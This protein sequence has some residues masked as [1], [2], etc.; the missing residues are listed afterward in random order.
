MASGTAAPGTTPPAESSPTLKAG[1]SG[2]L[3]LFF[4]VGDMIGAG[5]FALV[6]EVGG[7]VGGAIWSAFAAALILAILTAGAYAELVTK[8]PRAG[9]AATYV[10]R[11]YRRHFVTFIIAFLVMASGV[12]SAATLS[13]AFAGD[14]FNQF[15]DVPLVPVALGFI[16]LVGLINFRGI[17]E[18][19]K[20]NLVLTLGSLLGLALIVVIGVAAVADGSA[21]VGRN[22]EFTEG[23]SVFAAV[24]AGAALAFYAL[25]GF[26]DSVNVAEETP[27]PTRSFPRTLFGG[28]L[29]AGIVYMLVT[30]AASSVVPT[31]DLA[32]SDGPLLEVVRQGP[33][34]L[35]LKLFAVVALMAV[36]NGALLNMIMASRLTYGM[37]TQGVVPRAFGR[38][39]AGRRTP[40]VA[41][42]FTTALAIVL[43]LTGD[44][45]LL[46]DVT[47]TL[48][49]FVFIVV[50]ATVIVLRRDRVEHDHFRTPI[51]LP[52][53]GIVTCVALLTQRDA[54]VWLRAG[55]I[56]ALGVVL[57]AVTR[58]ATGPPEDL[59]TERMR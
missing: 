34:D 43:I 39:H 27:N 52:V 5:I 38:V 50:N 48:L 20:L 9:G 42:I 58:M 51:V 37:G 16:V 49:L 22:L 53:L 41:I 19:V 21:D 44:L 46:A 15:V 59:E 10:N 29:I 1:I 25:I 23:S 45:E 8:Y 2:G 56:L 14:Y 40:W 30:V 32:G 54:E 47:V 55:L 4:I 36:A 31:E 26:E 17:S 7:K 24:L 18:S 28:L 35:P 57:Y 3:L 6:G 12:T 13:R 11:A 33:I